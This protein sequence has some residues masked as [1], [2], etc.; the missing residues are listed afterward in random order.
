MATMNARS[1][2]VP[3]LSETRNGTARIIMLGCIP[4]MSPMM[5]P[6]AMPRRRK[7]MISNTEYIIL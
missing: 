6:A 7:K 3:I 5:M 2:S 4:G 1:G